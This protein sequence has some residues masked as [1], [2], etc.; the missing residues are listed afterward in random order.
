MKILAFII[1][2]PALIYGGFHLWEYSTGGKYIKYLSENSETI[3]LDETF[4]YEEL[5]KDVEK[6]RLVLL[7]E[8][9]GFDEPNK[10]DLDFF[11]YLNKNHNINHYIA[12]VDFVQA[13]LL[14]EFL[15]TG[16][17]NTL[18][19]ALK[20]WAVMQGRNN[21]DYFNKYL[22]LHK[23]YQE[24]PENKRFEFIGVDRIQDGVL[25]TSYLT[26]LYPTSISEN[27]DALEKKSRVELLEEL[28]TIYSENPDT[29]FILSHLKSN[30]EYIKEKVDRDEIM[31]RNFKSI[32]KK[33]KLE[34]SKLYGF[35]GLTHVFQYRVNGRHPF[36]S[37]VRKS[38][39][40]FQDKILSINM[41]MNDSH[42]VMVSNQLPEMMRDEGAYTKMPV[43]ADNMLFIYIVGVK[44]FKRMTPEYHKSLIKMNDN[45]SPYANSIRLNKTIQLLPVTDVLE[46]TDKGKPYVQYTVFVR[47]SDWAEPME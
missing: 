14:N 33:D 3:P 2:I 34:D 11:K 38:D 30:V 47:N 23:Y 16:D 21:K 46:M 17:E 36:A 8:I 22:E 29:L 4:T 31:F 10:F 42:M 32:Y 45:D 7:G 13:S 5:G 24:L 28:Q 12:E 19:K 18:K 27:K 15:V 44:D 20:K 25:L 9:H 1:L 26:Q 37:L 39:L 43:S 40:G 41:M 35:F 6:N